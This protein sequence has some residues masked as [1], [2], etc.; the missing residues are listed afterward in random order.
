MAKTAA[1]RGPIGAWLVSERNARG[2]HSAAVARG[3]LERAQVLRVAPSVYAE[4]EA[5]TKRPNAAQ[6]E[7]L[8]RFY[9]SE[10]A[11]PSPLDASSGVLV[12]MLR[13]Q[14]RTNELLVARLD[15]VEGLLATLLAGDAPAD[16]SSRE[17]MRAWGSAALDRSR[18]QGRQRAQTPSEP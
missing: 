5:G 16:P 12:E 7:A 3:A 9:G 1:E 18:S 4:W 17:A 11:K 15:A 10:P 14:Q 8:T 13:A 6:M 2:W